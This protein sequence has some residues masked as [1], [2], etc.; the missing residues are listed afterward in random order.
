MEPDVKDTPVQLS[1][2]V[3]TGPL[4]ADGC[5]NSVAIWLPKSRCER[6]T[7]SEK[8]KPQT[9]FTIEEESE[10]KWTVDF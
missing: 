1:E 9:A 5:G 3:G 4:R 7:V 8:Q 2:D 10:E 6:P